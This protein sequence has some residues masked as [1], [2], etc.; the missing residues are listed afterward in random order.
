MTRT[1]AINRNGR[2]TKMK[3]LVYA[4]LVILLVS[5]SSPTAQTPLETSTPD[6]KATLI[7]S[8]PTFEIT[9]D[10]NNCIVDGPEEITTG[11]HLFVLHDLSDLSAYHVV[12]RMFSD[13]SFEEEKKWVEE[14]C[15][16]PGSHCVKDSGRVAGYQEKKQVYDEDGDL[17]KLIDLTFEVEHAIWVGNPKMEWWPCGSFQVVAAP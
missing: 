16:P 10:G 3:W 2:E 15:G 14:N 8:P 17:Y 12:Q 13:H 7:A 9:F 6:V 4:F 11:E 1:D 5:C